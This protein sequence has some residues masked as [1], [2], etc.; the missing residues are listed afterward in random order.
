M[1]RRLP[2]SINILLLRSK[3]NILLLRSK[4]NILL[5]RSKENILLLRSKDYLCVLFAETTRMIASPDGPM[6][7]VPTITGSDS[8]MLMS[9]DTPVLS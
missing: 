7:S 5:L 6:L 3:E 4:E 9:V 2:K 8:R 1:S